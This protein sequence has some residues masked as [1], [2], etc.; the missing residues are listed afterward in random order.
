MKDDLVYLRHILDCL[1]AIDAYTVDGRAAFF[2]DRK[3]SPFV[4]FE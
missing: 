3:T 4:S 2:E 1:D